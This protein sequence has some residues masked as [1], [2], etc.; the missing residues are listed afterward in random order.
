ML[1][2]HFQLVGHAPLTKG[3]HRDGHLTVWQRHPHLPSVIT[4]PV[5]P[6]L[7]LSVRLR[8]P[9]NALRRERRKTDNLIFVF[10]QNRLT[11]VVGQW[12]VYPNTTVRL[13]LA[14]CQFAFRPQP[15]QRTLRTF[16]RLC[17][18][19]LNLFVNN[20]WHHYLLLFCGTL[21]SCV[22]VTLRCYDKV[23]EK[24]PPPECTM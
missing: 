3:I 1:F 5:K 7:F 19:H 23:R 4:R 17:R 24:V 8:T 13:S 6:S 15:Q 20:L 16:V 9:L 2:L 18:W 11:F 12:P 22:S 14:L 21:I 10:V